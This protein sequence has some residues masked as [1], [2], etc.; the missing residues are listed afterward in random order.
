ML[1]NVDRWAVRR[2]FELDLTG[3]DQ[4]PWST[5]VAGEV[6]APG[7]PLGMAALSRMEFSERT[8]TIGGKV[9]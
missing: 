6:A 9:Q 8:G 2:G 5:R 3:V 4:N 1:R 7:R